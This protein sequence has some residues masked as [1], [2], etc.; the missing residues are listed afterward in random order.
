MV[1]AVKSSSE[2]NEESRVTRVRRMENAVKSSK[3][4]R[5]RG[6]ARPIGGL[7]LVQV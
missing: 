7:K 6:V 4:T 1:D 3:E 2:R 5:F